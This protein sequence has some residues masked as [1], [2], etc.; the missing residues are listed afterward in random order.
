V[1]KYLQWACEETERNHQGEKWGKTWREKETWD[2]TR[3][4]QSVV[5]GCGEY[6]RKPEEAVT[7]GAFFRKRT[8]RKGDLWTQ[9]FRQ[10]RGSRK[11][12]ACAKR[13]LGTAK[14]K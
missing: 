7:S 10:T 9:N 4:L 8:R 5:V 1:A 11:I 2:P 12:D 3:N 13:G 14:R 6:E